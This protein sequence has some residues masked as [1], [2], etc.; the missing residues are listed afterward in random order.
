MQQAFG[1]GEVFIDLESVGPGV[2]WGIKIESALS[3]AKV[4]VLVI[5]PTWLTTT[6][7]Y[8]RRC[9]DDE[10]DWVAKE[11]RHAIQSGLA[12]FPV[13]VGGATLP[14]AEALP[15]NLASLVN[16]QAVELR[17]EHWSDGRERLLRAVAALGFKRSVGQLPPVDSAAKAYNTRL[18]FERQFEVLR[19]AVALVYRARNAIRNL[20]DDLEL[21]DN[22]HRLKTYHEAIESLMFEER[23]LLPKLIFDIL[24]GLKHHLHAAAILQ[25]QVAV[26]ENSLH[27]QPSRAG[28]DRRH[29]L[30]EGYARIDSDYD[31]LLGAV[32]QYIGVSSGEVTAR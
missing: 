19:D 12:I 27:A 5:G 8:G 13:L 11:L 30:V 28:E 14:V 9:I 31:D 21:S 29:R 15:P 3:T 22:L 24:H 23:A 7:K 18:V 26:S 17:D 10:T 6:D 1:P 16:H 4:L 25:A 20:R 32:Q 2:E